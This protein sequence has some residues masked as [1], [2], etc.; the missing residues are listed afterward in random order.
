V[1]SPSSRRVMVGTK[2]DPSVSL[3]GYRRCRLHD[4]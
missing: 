2:S 4:F 1:S 3:V